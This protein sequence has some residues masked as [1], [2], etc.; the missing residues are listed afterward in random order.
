MLRQYAVLSLARAS[1]RRNSS[2]KARIREHGVPA[3]TFYW[4]VNEIVVC[5]LTYLL[6]YDYI[7]GGDL[8]SVLERVGADKY[9]DLSK[10]ESKNWYL[11]DGR[12][13]ITARFLTNFAAA[14]AFMSILTPVKFPLIISMYPSFRRLLA[15]LTRKRK[16]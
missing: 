4:V 8:L 6:H 16:A 15:R 12:L 3:L 10:V 1:G 2:W 11:F 13:C 5:Y 9:M 14:S 7:G